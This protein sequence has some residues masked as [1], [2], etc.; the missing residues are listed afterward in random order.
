MNLPHKLDRTILIHASR[1]IVFRFFTDNERWSAWWGTGSTIEPRPGG[2][3][4]IRYPGGCRSHR[5]GRRGR[6]PG[7][8]R[9]HL[10]LHQRQADCARQFAG[11]DPSCRRAARH[12]ARSGSRVR[13]RSGPRRARPGLA[14]SAVGVRES[15]RGRRPSRRGRHRD[16]MVR[17]VERDGCRRT[18]PPARHHR[19]RQ[20]THAPTSTAASTASRN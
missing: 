17:G 3:V 11:D 2:R 8:A 4:V 18:P 13:R 16:E 9:L 12:A 7:T 19:E 5:R 15:G 1:D 6:R 20:R 14:L 10:R